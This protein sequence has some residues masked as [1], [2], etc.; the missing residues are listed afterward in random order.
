MFKKLAARTIS[1]RPRQFLPGGAPC[2]VLLE[3]VVPA[4]DLSPLHRMTPCPPAA[5]EALL[6]SA[7]AM[8]DLLAAGSLRELPGVCTPELF[9]TVFADVSMVSRNKV[10]VAQH[11]G[12]RVDLATPAGGTVTV[13]TALYEVLRRSITGTV[14]LPTVIDRVAPKWGGS[15]PVIAEL[16]SVLKPLMASGAVALIAVGT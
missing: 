6:G 7:G 14:P 2:V 3:P 11:G 13:T 10:A 5:A 8:R 16:V 4:D 1:R 9:R 15:G 12:G